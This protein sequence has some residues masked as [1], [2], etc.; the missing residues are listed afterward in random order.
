MKKTIFALISFT[1][2]G[3]AVAANADTMYVTDR[4]ML[5]VHQQAAETSTVVATIPSG[6]AVTVLERNNDFI[7]IQ[8]ANGTQ[9]W[10]S[11][12]YMSS[13][14]PATAQVDA[15]NAQLKQAQTKIQ[16]LQAEIKKRARETQTREDEISNDK[17]TIKEL[18]NKLKKQLASMPSP[19]K[20]AEQEIKQ[21]KAQVKKLS[22]DKQS[23]VKET[24]S[25]SELSLR[26]LQKENQQLQARIAAAVANLKGQQVPSASQL[27]SIQPSFPFWYWILLLAIFVGGVTAGFGWFDYHH[28][29]RHGGFRI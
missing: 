15:V 28:R 17:S 10:V 29:K 23:L 22:S 21:L 27:A 26:D 2:F 14:K 6:T 7:K 4:I 8:L 20:Q 24:K 19:S 3:L 11:S 9:G 12:A 1:L 13:S 5:G 16:N 18:Q 25:D